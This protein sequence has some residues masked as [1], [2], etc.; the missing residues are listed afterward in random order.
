MAAG[1]LVLG[2]YMPHFLAD[3]FNGITLSLGGK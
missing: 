1:I 2:F 3:V